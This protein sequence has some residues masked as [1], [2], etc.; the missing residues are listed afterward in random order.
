[1]ADTTAP[2]APSPIWDVIAKLTPSIGQ[3]LVLL[4]GCAV[5]AA[6]T[7]INQQ[8]TQKPTPILAADPPRP[9]PLASIADLDNSLNVHGAA[10]KTEIVLA[11]R[12]LLDE[13]FG[14]KAGGR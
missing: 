1:M 12:A 8:L 7:L 14:K 2:T 6:G 10:L 11:V 13:R 4:V 5:G 3:C 9:S